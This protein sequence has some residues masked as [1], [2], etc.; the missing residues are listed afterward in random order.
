MLISLLSSPHLFAK[1]CNDVDKNTSVKGDIKQA[2]KNR[3]AEAS[4][5]NYDFYTGKKGDTYIQVERTYDSFG[6]EISAQIKKMMKE[7]KDF[8]GEF[9][10]AGFVAVL[11]KNG[12][13]KLSEI[14][15][16]Q[17]ENTVAYIEGNSIDAEMMEKAFWDLVAQVGESNVAKGFFFH[18]HPPGLKECGVSEG[19]VQVFAKFDASARFDL[20]F[21]SAPIY[22][23]RRGTRTTLS[24]D[25]VK[26]E[27]P[28]VTGIANYP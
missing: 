21:Y 2:S 4:I 27:A 14:F 7:S 23:S 15:S 3:F 6:K 12:K 5:T 18:S 26:L 22:L 13:V 16:N 9:A 11:L 19:D 20:E 17:Q 8:Y 1:D 28:L 24:G 10:E 25:K